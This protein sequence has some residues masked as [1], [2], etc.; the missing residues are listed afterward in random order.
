M[1]KDYVLDT[2]AILAVWQGEDGSEDLKELVN[3]AGK[4]KKGIYVYKS[5]LMTTIESAE[6][7]LRGF[8]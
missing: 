6:D 5:L 8:M 1:A 3:E 7:Q 2:S 4:G